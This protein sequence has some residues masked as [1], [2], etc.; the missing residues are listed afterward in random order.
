M[1]RRFALVGCL[2]ASACGGEGSWQRCGSNAECPAG[3]YCNV[4]VSGEP[5]VC[6]APGTLVLTTPVAGAFVGANASAAATLTLAAAGL[7]TPATVELRLGDAS[8]ATLARQGAPAGQTATYAGTWNP[9]AGQ[10]GPGS[11][12]ALASVDVA[13]TAVPVTSPAVAV[14]VD[15]IPPAIQNAG[16]SCAG[17]CRR[18]SAMDVSAQA[19]DPNMLAVTVSL[20]LEP[21]RAV[22]VTRNGDVYSAS[23]ALAGWPFPYFDQPVNVTLR[24]VDRA[25]NEAT[26]SVAADVTRL[27]WA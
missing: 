9:G 6:Q 23:V 7:S 27:R 15:T 13:G 24:A 19:T 25:G 3:T 2:V 14:T 21:G 26:T 5:G 4:P 16:A 17:G 11:L 1:L 20:D 12:D 10:N 8:V 22:S 18:D